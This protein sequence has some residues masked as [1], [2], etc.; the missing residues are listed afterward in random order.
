[1]PGGIP[2]GRMAGIPA[3][4]A[5]PAG[6][7]AP[8]IGPIP[9]GAAAPFGFGSSLDLSFGIDEPSRISSA[10]LLPMPGTCGGGRAVGKG[11][12]WA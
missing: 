8:A 6:S 7:I 3:G 12:A 5:K 2:G 4:G 11:R 10:F 9:P 1:M